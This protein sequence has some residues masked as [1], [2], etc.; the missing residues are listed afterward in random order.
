MV[1]VYRV[2][3]EMDKFQYLAPDDVESAM[4][5]RY[6]RTVIRKAWKPLSTYHANPKKP[7]PDVWC[8]MSFGAVFAV[9]TNVAQQIVSFLDQSCETLPLKSENGKF[10]LCNVTCVVK[11]LDKKH[12]R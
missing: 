8:C 4:K 5:H 11:A 9:R 3:P 2:I 6:D 1:S 7:A 12:S 10:L